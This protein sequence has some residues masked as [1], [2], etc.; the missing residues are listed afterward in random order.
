MTCFLFKKFLF[1]FKWFIPSGMSVTDQHLLILNG[2]GSHVILKAIDQAQEVGLNMITLP[3]HT[4]HA[5]QALNVS[6]FKPFKTRFKKVT[7]TTMARNN[8]MELD[9]ITLVG[10]MDQALNQSLTKQNIKP[11]FRATCIYGFYNQDNRIQPSTIYTT[12]KN[13]KGGEEDHML[14]EKEH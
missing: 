2:H 11:R 3:S 9:K 13:I 5:L 14:N 6:Y 8:Y 12:I 1:F 10:C 7:N 4:F